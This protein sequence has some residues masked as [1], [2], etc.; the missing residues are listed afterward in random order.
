[1]EAMSLHLPLTTSISLPD[2]VCVIIKVSIDTENPILLS[3]IPVLNNAEEEEKDDDEKL[4]KTEFDS[5]DWT[6]KSAK[7]VCCGKLYHPELSFWNKI[8]SFKINKEMT[9]T[10][11]S[12]AARYTSFYIPEKR[13]MLDCGVVSQF[14]PEYI[15]ITHGHFDHSGEIPRTLIDTGDVKPILVIPKAFEKQIYNFID[16]AYKM[17][18]YNES[19]KIHK[20]YTMITVLPEQRIDMTIK[21]KPW[22][23]EIIKCSH[24]VPC[25]GYGFN[26]IRNKLNPEYASLSQEEIHKLIKGGTKITYTIEVPQFCFMG[27]TDHKVLENKNLEKYPVIIIECTFIDPEHIKEAKKT[28]HMHWDNLKSYISNHPKITFILIHFSARYPD[29]HIKQFFKKQ[30]NEKDDK[31]GKYENIVVWI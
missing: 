21:S 14:S 18:K 22:V 6:D 19:P 1:M 12:I 31:N 17:T 13:I 25:D 20:N 8:K 5:I 11:Y 3:I 4:Y 26:E 2:V 15:F 28:K 29:E 24:S 7:K 23:I 30:Q 16:C 9:L 27:D 10:G